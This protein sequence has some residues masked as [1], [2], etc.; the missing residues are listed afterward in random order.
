MS[1]KKKK[2]RL[3]CNRHSKYNAHLSPI[4]ISGI[5]ESL[6]K[7]NLILARTIQ[8]ITKV[9]FTDVQEMK[10]LKEYF[11]STYNWPIWNN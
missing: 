5:K 10:R 2:K 1:Q 3:D 11:C 7:T 4:A 6:A 8:L 9:G